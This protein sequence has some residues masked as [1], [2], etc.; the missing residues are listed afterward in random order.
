MAGTHGIDIMAFHGFY[1]LAP[2]GFGHNLASN[3]AVIVTIDAAN[4]HG[5]AVD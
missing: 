3:I 5:L 1:V 4:E 2:M